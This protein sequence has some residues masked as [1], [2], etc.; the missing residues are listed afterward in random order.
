MALALQDCEPN[1]GALRNQRNKKQ[2]AFRLEHREPVS[3]WISVASSPAE[4][5]ACLPVCPKT[6]MRWGS[7]LDSGAQSEVLTE[8]AVEDWFWEERLTLSEG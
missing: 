4:H 1:L 3:T 6:L 2:G 8:Q 7:Q 5:V